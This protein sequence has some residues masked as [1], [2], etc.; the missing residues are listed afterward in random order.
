MKQHSPFYLSLYSLLLFGLLSCGGN[1]KKATFTKNMQTA[2]YGDTLESSPVLVCA[3]QPSLQNPQ[4]GAIEKPHKWQPGSIIKVKFLNGDAFFRNKVKRY[5][6]EW[7]KYAHIRFNF[8]EKGPANIR[9]S[10]YPGKGFWSYHG[11]NALYYSKDT[12]TMEDVRWND[13]P[14]MNFGW[15]TRK[16]P[17]AEFRQV[18]YHEFGHGLSLI[19]EHQNPSLRPISWDSAAVYA[20]HLQVDGWDSLMVNWNVFRK[21]DT[22]ITQYSAYDR[23]SI[24]HYAIPAFLVKDPADVVPWNSVLS[25]TDKAFI[26]LMYP[27]PIAVRPR[28]TERSG[29]ENGI[30]GR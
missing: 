8:V 9:V 14:S 13:G 26:A 3:E 29:S 4:K 21:Y 11:T 30:G 5:A 16:L 18:I 24:M 1:E 10:F 19:H 22:T 27:R 15:T 23:A 2:A 7:E 6:K 12:A 17:E 25:A 20:H 28:E